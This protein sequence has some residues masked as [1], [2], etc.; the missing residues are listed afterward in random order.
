M[1]LEIETSKMEKWSIHQEDLTMI[2]INASNNRTKM[3]MKQYLTG[4]EGEDN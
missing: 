3:Y 1:L 2:N 4:L